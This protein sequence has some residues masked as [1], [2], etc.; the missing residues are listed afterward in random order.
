MIQNA[1][2][3]VTELLFRVGSSNRL[4]LIFGACFIANKLV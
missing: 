3:R 4:I 1:Q 2:A